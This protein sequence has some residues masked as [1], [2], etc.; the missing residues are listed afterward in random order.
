LR[1]CCPIRTI[2]RIESRWDYDSFEKQKS[3][4]KNL[5]TNL[6]LPNNAVLKLPDGLSYYITNLGL[7]AEFDYFSEWEEVW[8]L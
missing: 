5:V 1:N 7:A 3:Q 8:T 2:W 4:N 6:P